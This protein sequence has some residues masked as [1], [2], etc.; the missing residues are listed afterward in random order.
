MFNM[1]F[2]VGLRQTT[3][4]K[5]FIFPAR[6]NNNGAAMWE[7]TVHGFSS[8]IRWTWVRVGSGGRAVAKSRRAL[9]TWTE[10]FTDAVANG[11]DR[12]THHYDLI[13]LRAA[14]LQASSQCSTE[15]TAV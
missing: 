7:F 4:E 14:P 15:T 5:S 1:A 12:A 6:Y 3:S 9:P 2:V 11:L 13:D 10:A 8:S